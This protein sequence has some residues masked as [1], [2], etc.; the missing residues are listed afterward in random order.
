MPEVL[1]EKSYGKSVDLFLF[2]LLMYEMLTGLPA[3]PFRDNYE[4]H[5]KRIKACD[6]RFPGEEG[7]DVV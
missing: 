3:F 7:C 6:F 2:G 4:E 1:A 5:Q